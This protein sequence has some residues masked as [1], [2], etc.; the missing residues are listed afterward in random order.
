MEPLIEEKKKFDLFEL[1]GWLVVTALYLSFVA[2]VY[3]TQS[4]M[5][6]FPNLSG[7]LFGA[8]TDGGFHM[9]FIFG[10]YRW[11]IYEITSAVFFL[12]LRMSVPAVNS[13]KAAHTARYFFTAR[14]L[15]MALFGLAYF[16]S[17]LFINLFTIVLNYVVTTAAAFLFMMFLTGK[18]PAG[19]RA[20][21]FRSAALPYLIYHGVTAAMAI[22]IK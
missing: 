5:V 19:I 7:G 14:N 11:A 15:V 6:L 4:L 1:P 3:E 21:A 22:L 16:F 8:E 20:R 17:P 13:R 10:L 9:Y 12:Y 2:G 18:L